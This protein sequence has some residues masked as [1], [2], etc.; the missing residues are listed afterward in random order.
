MARLMRTGLLVSTAMPHARIPQAVE[1]FPHAGI[2]RRVIQLVL[3]II[4]QEELE[5]FL[6]L[7]F[8]GLGAQ[9]PPDQHR[10]AVAHIGI[11]ALVLDRAAC[12]CGRAR[13]WRRAPGRS[14]ESIRVPSRSKISRSIHAVAAFRRARDSARTGLRRAFCV[15]KLVLRH[16]P[17]QRVAMDS[18]QLAGG[19]AVPAGALQRP[20][21]QGLLQQLDYLFQKKPVAYQMLHQ[22]F[23][24]LFHLIPFPASGNARMPFFRAL[25]QIVFTCS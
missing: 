25:P 13:R 20:F 8:G 9:H 21:D 23:E 18:Q 11:D 1:R 24:L 6:D 12:P 2:E 17:L 19:R 5:R 14:L 10:R 3:A 22:R 4:L 7:R 15:P 16:L